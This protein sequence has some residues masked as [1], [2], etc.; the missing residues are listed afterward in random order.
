M[1]Y[2]FDAP[3]QI[4]CSFHQPEVPVAWNRRKF[5][6]SCACFGLFLAMSRAFAVTSRKPEELPCWSYHGS[7]GPEHWGRLHPDWATCAEGLE[8]SPIALPGEEAG[9]IDERLAFRYRP[10]A[11]RLSDSPHTV[12]VNMKPGS[13]LILGDQVFSLRQFHFHTPS[14]HLW[15]DGADAAELHLVHV[16]D[17]GGIIVL[18][19]AL[20]LDAPQAFPESFWSW[21]RAAKAGES[22]TLD[23]AALVPR[24]GHFMGYRGSFTTPPCAEG[25]NWLLA[26]EP[27]GL[28]ASDQRW[29]EQR[30]GRNARPVQPLGD[31]TVHMVRRDGS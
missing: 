24:Q 5:L 20:R 31:R 17:S 13:Q 6:G 25:V 9:P 7:E 28:G 8:Q 12:R 2:H 10:T 26:A 23:P 15:S 11:G 4:E 3:K 19:V 21:L 14:E 27:M 16:A 18:G 30:M 22:Q 1:A 29:L